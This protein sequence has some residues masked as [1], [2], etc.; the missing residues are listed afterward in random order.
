M[1]S[2]HRGDVQRARRSLVVAMLEL[3]VA[4][5]RA[6]HAVELG[7]L[8]AETFHNMYLA[9]KAAVEADRLL[10]RFANVD[11]ASSYR[12]SADATIPRRAA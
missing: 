11:L 9:H 2:I 4:E 12:H 7:E 8:P 3:E 6:S 5:V 10:T 1:P